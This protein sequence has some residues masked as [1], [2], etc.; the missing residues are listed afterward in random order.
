MGLRALQL[1]L[2]QYTGHKGLSPRKEC[3]SNVINLAVR[4]YA[5]CGL[6]LPKKRSHRGKAVDL[7]A[8]SRWRLSDIFPRLTLE[9]VV[10]KWGEFRLEGQ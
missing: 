9:S 1:D 6:T 10:P 3:R 4:T 8:D 2:I 7:S 5:C